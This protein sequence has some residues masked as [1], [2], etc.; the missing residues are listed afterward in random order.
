MTSI[1]L[2]LFQKQAEGFLAT[3][4]CLYKVM[5]MFSQQHDPLVINIKAKGKQ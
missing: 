2:H 1:I 5:R 4:D 3:V